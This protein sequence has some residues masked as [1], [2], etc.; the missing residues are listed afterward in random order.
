MARFAAL[1]GELTAGED[2]RHGRWRRRPQAGKHSER[3]ARSHVVLV[4]GLGGS[5]KSRLLK[6]FQY[7]ALGGLADLS[8]TEGM[9]RTAWLDW[10][11]ERGVDPSRYAGV[12]GP[13]LVTVLDA[14]R[15]AV[16]DAFEK[17]TRAR[18]RVVDAFD[19]Y[20]QGAART[21]EYAPRCADGVMQSG[22]SGSPFTRQIF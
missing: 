15:R 13:S 6:Q 2:I 17:G 1:L 10:A 3:A 5:G 7:M 22:Q 16:I 14:V 19:E 12:E 21:P 8:I 4:H 20:C 18:E 9:I 11:D